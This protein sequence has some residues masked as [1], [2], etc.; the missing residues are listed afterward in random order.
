MKNLFIFGIIILIIAAGGITIGSEK[1]TTVSCC[2]VLVPLLSTSFDTGQGEYPSISGTHN[3]TI[4][5]FHDIKVSTLYTYP[6]AGTGGH[7][8]YVRFENSTWNTTASWEGYIG[9]WYNVSFESPFTLVAGKTYN[10]TIR[11][12]SYPQIQYMRAL[13][14]PDG[15]IN[16]TSFTDTNGKVYKGWIPSIRLYE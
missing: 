14:T 4:T 8:E 6:C 11:T 13:K 10:Y 7:I 16:C 2:F 1:D 3:G 12:D 5:P 15:W 9:D